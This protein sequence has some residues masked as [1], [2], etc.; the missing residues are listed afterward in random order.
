M[1]TSRWL[2]LNF[3]G[4]EP[5]APAPVDT[6]EGRVLRL[7][8]AAQPPL[9]ILVPFAPGGR[10]SHYA[11]LLAQRLPELLGR[12]VRVE[13]VAQAGEADYRR[14]AEDASDA[15]VL[16]AAVRLPR[17]G[18]AGVQ[19]GPPIEDALRALRPVTLLASQPLVLAIDR[20]R[21]DA[22]GI[23]SLDELLAYARAHPGAL[24]V[25]TGADGWTGQLAYGQF[26]ALSGVDVRRKIFDGMYPDSDR[27]TRE[28]AAD[29]L[30]APV[31]GAIVAVRRGQL[32]VLGTT[33]DPHHPLRFEGQ[34]W[35]SL[36][37]TPA[38]AGYNAYDRFSLW[39]PAR[40]QA[41]SN[42]A[43]Q[44]A[45]A[46]ALD[47]APVRQQLADLQAI[48]GGGPPEE[49]LGLEDEERERWLRALSAPTP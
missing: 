12:E 27:I 40:S 46:Q 1:A 25:A 37:S 6:V 19:T 31:N 7:S 43:L 30:F 8:P 32:R 48:G 45:V 47:A 36:A 38:L 39:A 49:L 34:D 21:S 15:T 33:A 5:R 9:R 14:F 4:Q 11:E 13:H 3:G 44:Q 2:S 26:R 41:A 20:E 22:L 28:H 42:R 29:L 16:L 10:S 35:P 24:S 23:R 17:G 18:I